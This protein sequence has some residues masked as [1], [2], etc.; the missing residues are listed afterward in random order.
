MRNL[1]LTSAIAAVA[2]SASAAQAAPEKG[3]WSARIMGGVDFPVAGNLHS[4][5]NAPVAN[6][7]TLNPALTGTAGTLA[8]E[9][10]PNSRFYNGGIGANV[11]LGYAVRDG[12]EIFGAFRYQNIGRG[13]GPVGEV[14]VPSQGANLPINAS[15]SRL[16][17]FTGEVGY[18]Q[19]LSR[20]EIQPYVA[21]RAGVT[22]TN[23]I[24]A[25]FAVP[26]AG[27]ALNDVPFY[28][29]SVS[30][31]VGG[32]IGVAIPIASRVDLN[33]E[34]GIRWTSGLRGDDTALAGLGLAGIN[35]AGAR[36]DVPVRA[37]LNFRF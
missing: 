8:I 31:T 17:A 3:Q 12:G 22:F 16:R 30:G 13:A 1:L 29:N 23:R 19:Y 7:G 21:G 37:G 33:I 11:E 27:I 5:A 20:G 26:G 9:E 18:R 6:L 34:S 10:A 36:W 25:D 15:F 35:N 28:K 32:D 4:G 24:N 14:Q 2:L